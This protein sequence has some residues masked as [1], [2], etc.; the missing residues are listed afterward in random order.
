MSWCGPSDSES[1]QEMFESFE[2]MWGNRHPNF[3][4]RADPRGDPREV[5]P[6]RGSVNFPLE[7][8]VSRRYRTETEAPSPIEGCGS[9]SLGHAR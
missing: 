9:Q 6:N 8:D 1:I 3:I 4:V 2:A 5:A 7:L